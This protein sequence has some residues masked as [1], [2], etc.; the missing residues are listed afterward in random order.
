MSVSVETVVINLIEAFG[1][2][3]YER[4][5][6]LLGENVQSYVTNAD[7]GATLADG[8]EAYMRAI[9]SVDYKT[10]GPSVTITQI[11]TVK[12]DQVMVMVEIK[13]ERKGRSL[14]NFAAFLMDVVDGKIQEMHMVEALPA[15]SDEFWKA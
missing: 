10:V 11:L 14:H 13:A 9:E 3:D 5:A 2:G 4:M 6:D 1:R 7:G 15:Y 8:R 12:P